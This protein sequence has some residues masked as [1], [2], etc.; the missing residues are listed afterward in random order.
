MTPSL[1]HAPRFSLF[2]FFLCPELLCRFLAMKFLLGSGR[3][4]GE[5]SGKVHVGRRP[6]ASGGG[7]QAA[8]T[9]G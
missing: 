2:R 5:Q 7:T 8:S 1:R 3:D 9:P 6:P 4:S